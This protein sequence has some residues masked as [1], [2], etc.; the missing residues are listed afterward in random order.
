M[1]CTDAEMKKAA[2]YKVDN[3]RRNVDLCLHISSACSTVLIDSTVGEVQY[4]VQVHESEHEQHVQS[5]SC[6]LPQP[7]LSTRAQRV[8]KGL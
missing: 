3:F 2:H 7:L 5:Y 8:G 1:A 4:H 6:G